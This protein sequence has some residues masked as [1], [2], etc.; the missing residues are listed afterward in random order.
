[1]VNSRIFLL[2]SLILLFKSELDFSNVVIFS[3]FIFYFTQ[4]EIEAYKDIGIN[5]GIDHFNKFYKKALACNR[6]TY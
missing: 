5:K 6:T 1:M 4:K 3:V 2:S